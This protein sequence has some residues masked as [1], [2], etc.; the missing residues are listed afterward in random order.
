MTVR[1]KDR[2]VIGTDALEDILRRCQVCY[3]AF[4]GEAYPY[5]VPLNFGYVREGEAF[6]LYF[7]CATEGKKLEMMRKNPRVAIAMDGDSRLVA[8]GESAAAYTMAYESLMATG[9]LRQV[10]GPEKETGLSALMRQ[11]APEKTFA[12]DDATLGRVAVLRLDV[13]GLTGKR[14]RAEA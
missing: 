14:N 6:T 10:E 3:V 12:F 13:E 7:H 9:T 11:Y 4:Q 1:R 5:V 2:E 8:K